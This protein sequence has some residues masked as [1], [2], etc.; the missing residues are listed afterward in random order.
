[1]AFGDEYDRFFQV[2]E[3][4]CHTKTSHLLFFSFIDKYCVRIGEQMLYSFDDRIEAN[5]SIKQQFKSRIDDLTVDLTGMVCLTVSTT[6][7][8][9]LWCGSLSEASSLRPFW[10][11]WTWIVNFFINS[12]SYISFCTVDKWRVRRLPGFYDAHEVHMV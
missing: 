12:F 8:I 6:T 2:F 5:W 11:W 4:L 10:R 1:M 9:A 3:I 7:K